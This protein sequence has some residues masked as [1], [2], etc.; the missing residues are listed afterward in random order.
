MRFSTSDRKSHQPTRAA[1]GRNRE[2]ASIDG[3][4]TPQQ[5]VRSQRLAILEY[6]RANDVRID[7]FI[8]ATASG[9][10][11]EK[12]RRLDELTGLLQRGDRLVVSELSRLGR[13]LGQV[14]AVA[15]RPDPKNP[16]NSTSPMNKPL[17]PRSS[18]RSTCS[19]PS[20]SMRST[21]S[22]LCRRTRTSTGVTPAGSPS[23]ITAAP[24]G[25]DRTATTCLG[26]FTKEQP[27]TATAN[28]SAI[29]P[30]ACSPRMVIRFSP[31]Y[32]LSP[33]Y[34]RS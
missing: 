9:Q 13:S 29:H 18:S 16:A 30:L 33:F 1:L 27:D 19:N 2:D 31:F 34:S 10:A 17:N 22:A 4:L 23:S 5:D 12:R 20:F 3:H 26:P 25:V 6:A 14:V 21:G 24:V 8:E 15:R 28:A 7:E 32:F 11:S